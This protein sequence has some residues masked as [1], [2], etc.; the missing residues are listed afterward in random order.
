MS[1]ESLGD[2]WNGRG[3][4]RE[5]RATREIELTFLVPGTVLIFVVRFFPLLFG[6]DV[7]FPPVVDDASD[8]SLAAGAFQ[9]ACLRAGSEGD[10]VRGSL[11]FASVGAAPTEQRRRAGEHDEG[12]QN[13]QA[14]L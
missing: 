11:L 3:S 8:F 7:D 1:D 2:S 10:G 14:D 9:G 4:R 12:E 13:E 6:F 5:D